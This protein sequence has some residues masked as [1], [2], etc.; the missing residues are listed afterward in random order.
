MKKL[1]GLLVL[2]AACLTA[3]SDDDEN[4]VTGGTETYDY[5][6]VLTDFVDNTVIPTYA[7]MKDNALLLMEATAKFKTSG[8]QTDIQAACDYWKATRKGWEASEAFLFGPAASK[9]LD[10]LL[11]SWP[12]DQAQLD[13]VLAGDEVLTADYVRDAL[14]AVLRGFHTVEYLLFR[15]GAA[16]EV[17]DVTER[18]KAYLVAVTEVLRDD[19]L[20][21]W[22]SW[23]GVTAGT[24]EAE[25]LE[26]LDIS[27]P[28]PFGDEIKD[29]GSAG[30]RY[31]SQTDA[32]DEILQGMIDIADEVAN[33]KIADPV[34]SGNVL[35]VE[36][37]FSWNS[38]T[39]FKNNIRSIQN[40]YT[41]GYDGSTPGASI[42]DYVVEKDADLNA[43]VVAQIN[44]S[45]E[46]LNAIPEPF[47]NN[48]DNEAKVNAAMDAI[49][50]LKTSLEEDVRPLFFD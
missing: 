14:G 32:V 22:A 18:E 48:L 26:G 8:S 3:C 4:V 45:I 33:G 11:D 9:S 2:G 29:A 12:L 41:N 40:S 21:L 1:I 37:W 38:L 43:T 15:D 5:S 25:I 13:Q 10:P 39:D 30:S 31:L 34:G 20:N 42:S 28:I 17:S 7:D 36:S 46:A 6:V 44:A 27:I 49:N 19:C 16:R 23:A 35:D 47:R 50:A 24:T